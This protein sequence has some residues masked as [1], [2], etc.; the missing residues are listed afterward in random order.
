MRPLPKRNDMNVNRLT[1]QF[2]DEAASLEMQRN[3]LISNQFKAIA[4]VVG[5]VVGFAAVKAIFI[6]NL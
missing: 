2:A 5:G 6:R 3:E 1:K 4:F